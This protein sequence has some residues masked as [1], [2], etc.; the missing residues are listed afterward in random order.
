MA[1]L[2]AMSLPAFC[3]SP[4]TPGGTLAKKHVDAGITCT[5]CHTSGI[6]AKKAAGDSNL[7]RLATKEACLKCHGSY[8]ELAEKTVGYQKPF[9]PH[10]SHY[11]ELNCYTC[12][13][14]HQASEQFCTSCHME[15]KV[16]NGWKAAKV[17]ADE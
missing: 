12:H 15:M 11:G 6:P 7:S 9:N 5:Q 14:V 13:R 16:P 8:K 17:P 2:C 1:L 3:S 4:S 10:Y